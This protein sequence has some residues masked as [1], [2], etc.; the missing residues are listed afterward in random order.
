[1]SDALRALLA[2]LP[3][4][5]DAA[6]AAVRSRS[7]QVLRPSGA[8]RR[9]DDLAVHMAAWH[10][11]ATPTVA[12]PEVIV[13]AADHGVAAGGVSNYPS[14]VTGAMFAAVASGRATINALARSVGAEVTVFDVGVGSPTGDIR[15]EAAV[16]AERCDEIT[17]VAVRAVDEAADRDA[18]VIVLGELGIGNT[19]AAAAL[20]ASL[21]GGDAAA[22]VGRGTG[23]DDEGLARKCAAV[24]E[25][26]RR[27]AEHSDPIT[28]MC[29]VGGAELIAMAAACLQARR[30]R[31]PVVLDGYIA[32]AAVLPLHIAAPNSLDHCVVGHVSA[33]PGHRRLLDHID[34]QPLL[35]LEFRLGEGSGAVAALPL[36]R[37]ACAAVTETATFDEWFGETP[38][39]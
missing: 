34:K 23:V 19:T 29:E 22:W 18:D 5:D 26:A 1:M 21:L 39:S 20:P 36:I 25:A 11:T 7:E 2:D 3:V 31:I 24:A 16:S 27:V 35:D 10:A 14:E 38:T 13:F 15:V 30:R 33:E 4:A 28:V 32:T 9:L 37:M 12:R 8:L 17:G 6:A